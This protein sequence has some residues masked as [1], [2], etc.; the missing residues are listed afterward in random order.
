LTARFGCFSRLCFPHDR[1]A[2]AR[3]P[4]HL[5]SA[6]WSCPIP[7]VKG[8]KFNGKVVEHYDDATFSGKMEMSEI[9]FKKQKRFSYQKE[10]RV[11]VRGETTGTDALRFNMGDISGFSGKVKSSEINKEFQINLKPTKPAS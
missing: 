2:G 7:Q 4:P 8:M 5:W 9:P 10:F 11:C 6:S 1:R 3:L